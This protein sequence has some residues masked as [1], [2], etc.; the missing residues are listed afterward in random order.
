MRNLPRSVFATPGSR[1]HGF[2]FTVPQSNKDFGGLTVVFAA[3]TAAISKVRG[4]A[5]DCAREFP[6]LLT[7]AVV[8]C[9]C[10]CVRRPTRDRAQMRAPCFAYLTI[11]CKGKRPYR[12]AVFVYSLLTRMVA[13]DIVL[14]VC[15]WC[16]DKSDMEANKFVNLPAFFRS[17]PA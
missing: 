1:A 14:I 17:D 3:R 16:L 13:P 2:A 8:V 12:G 6:P 10:V 4:A 5:V 7:R 11:T 15:S 9:L